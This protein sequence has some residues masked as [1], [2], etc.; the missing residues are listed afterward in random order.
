MR[1][2][3]P[4]HAIRVIPNGVADDPPVRDR[5]AL[6]AELGVDPGA[7]LAVL[8][9][10]L[11]P[12]KRA[13]MFVEQ[14][15]H[16]ARAPS[17]PSTA[18]WWVTGRMHRR[19]SAPPGS[20][21]APCASLGFRADAVDIMH[22]ADVVCLTS[23][24]EALPMSVLEAMSVARPVV[25]L[26]VGGVP[27]AVADGETGLLIA[28]DRPSEMATALV[29]LARDAARAEELGRAGRA[30]QQRSFSIQ[31]MTRRYAE[32][33]AELDRPRRAARGRAR[34]AMAR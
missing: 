7:F 21:A 27:E 22:A 30:R 11:R 1:D 24:V 28:P 32:L 16:S 15:D 5:A 19:W 10:A 25:A 2:G 3:Y 26:G 23:A 6:R 9:A 20:L 29:G 31:A 12:E 4:P 18:S 34:E 8:V 33:L 17:R 13:S 14:V